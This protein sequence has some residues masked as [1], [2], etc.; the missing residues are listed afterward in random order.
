MTSASLI[1]WRAW[2]QIPPGV[3]ED[4]MKIIKKVSLML[5]EKELKSA[6]AA[7]I[8]GINKYDLSVRFKTNE[9]KFRFV[10]NNLLID[11]EG[12]FEEEKL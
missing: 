3:L 2:V 9:C 12:F 8:V 11:I 1:N 10:E 6:I 4:D 5:S 7:Y